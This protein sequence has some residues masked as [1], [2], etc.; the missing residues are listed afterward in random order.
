[1]YVVELKYDD[2]PERLQRRPAHR[3]LLAEWHEAGVVRAAGPFDDGTG[4]M[5]V[6][7]VETEDELDS[8]M[9]EDPYYESP[10][11]TVVS[12]RRWTPLV[13]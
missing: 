5:L 6:F 9:A 10:G 13:S 2:N 1:M 3:Q 8:F 7:D 11:L 4:A 12:R